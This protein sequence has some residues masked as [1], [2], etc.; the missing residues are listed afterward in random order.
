[1]QPLTLIFPSNFRSLNANAYNP[2]IFPSY[3]KSIWISNFKLTFGVSH[4]NPNNFPLSMIYG[5]YQGILTCYTFLSIFLSILSLQT[6]SHSQFSVFFLSQNPH[7]IF[8][9]SLKFTFVVLQLVT[10][11][12]ITQI[13]IEKEKMKVRKKNKQAPLI[14]NSTTELDKVI[15]KRR[16][17]YRTYCRL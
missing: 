11:S 10:N 3:A 6:Q 2:I 4:A 9:L 14:P 15:N 17:Q 7:I 16:L 1:M 13:S 12:F 5:V 8:A